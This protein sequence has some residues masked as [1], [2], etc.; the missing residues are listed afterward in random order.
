MSNQLVGKITHYFDKIAVA[1]LEVTQGEVKV[2]DT[3][4]IGEDGLGF[5]QTV[6][7]MQVDHASVNVAKAGDEVGLKVIQEVKKGDNVYQV[8]V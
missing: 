3:I 6:D 2:G 1:V 4:Q 8:T 5:S 7:S